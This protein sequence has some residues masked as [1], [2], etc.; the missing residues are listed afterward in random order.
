MNF[1]IYHRVPSDLCGS[2]LYPLNQL[3]IIY[4][5]VYASKV[6]NYHGRA[7]VMQTRIPILNCLWNDVLHFSPVHPAKIHAAREAAGFP[8]RTRTYFEIDPEEMGFNGENAVIFYHQH[9]QLDP[10]MVTEKDFEPFKGK[11]LAPL[12]EVPEATKVYYQQVKAKGQL[13]LVYLY[14]PHILYRGT[15]DTNKARVIQVE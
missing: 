9:I 14:V 7:V 12:N 3:K 2:I 4:P 1:Y 5:E 8:K 11:A 10:F 6:K 15:I 13:P